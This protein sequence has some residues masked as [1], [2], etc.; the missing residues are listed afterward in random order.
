M[1]PFFRRLRFLYQKSSEKDKRLITAIQA[2]VGSKPFNLDLYKLAT[3]H[4]SVA[5]ESLLGIKESNERLEYLGDAVLGAVVAEFLFKKFPYKDEGFLTEIRSRIVNRESLNNL[6][7]KIGINKI[8]EFDANRKNSLSHKSLYGDTLEAFVGAVYL[9]RGFKFCQ[10]FILKKL[11]IPHFNLDEIVNTN[12]NYKSK[13]IE[14][15]QREN[16]E[17]RFELLEVKT[18]KHF[19]EFIAQVF[20][21]EEPVSKGFGFSKKKAEQD[22]AQKSCEVL[23]L[24]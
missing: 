14:W 11:I 17:V 19:K 18:N 4:S 9:D 3:Q 24:T 1:L 12:P 6:A 20:I 8:V 10:R 22:A 21:N 2:I 5:K 13:I 16:K 15:A 23:K 7:K